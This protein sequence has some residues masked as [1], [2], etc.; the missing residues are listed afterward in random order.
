MCTHLLDDP[1]NPLYIGL[2]V[3]IIIIALVISAMI[4]II[5]I[6]YLCYLRR[7]EQTQHQRHIP[8]VS[9]SRN[10]MMKAET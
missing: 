1:T 7:K 3:A 10:P 2:T 8:T 9:S 5:G 4:I 6:Y